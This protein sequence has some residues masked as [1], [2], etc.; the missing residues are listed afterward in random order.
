[1][2]KWNDSIR[3]VEKNIK[4]ENEIENQVNKEFEININMINSGN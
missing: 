1:M 4:K 3:G 2:K